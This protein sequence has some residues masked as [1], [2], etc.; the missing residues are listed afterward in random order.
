MNAPLTWLDIWA[1]LFSDV[2]PHRVALANVA[3]GPN[4]VLFLRVSLDPPIVTPGV[5]SFLGMWATLDLLPESVFIALPSFWK[6][7]KNKCYPRNDSL[8]MQFL[9]TYVSLQTQPIHKLSNICVIVNFFVYLL[10]IATYLEL[11]R[12]DYGWNMHIYHFY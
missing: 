3:G 12:F 7:T 2:V 11:C 5:A 9:N 4:V 1:V 6:V 10:F 8:M